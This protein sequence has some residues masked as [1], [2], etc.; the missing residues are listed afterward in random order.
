MALLACLRSY[1][2]VGGAAQESIGKAAKTKQVIERT[3][4]QTS[5]WRAGGGLE[6]GPVGGDQRLTAVWQNEHELQATRHAGLPKDLQRLSLKW[7]MRTRDS[8]A[9][10][11]VLMV[12]SVWWFPLTI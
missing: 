2:Q 5:L 10:G 1:W 8:H 7:V 3:D 9:F 6:I 4:Q 12:G 11:E